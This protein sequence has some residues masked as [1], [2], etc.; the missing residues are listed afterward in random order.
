MTAESPYRPYPPPLQVARVVLRWSRLLMV[1]LRSRGRFKFTHGRGINLAKR[2]DIRAPH[3]VELGD[4][5]FFGKNFTCETD[6]R[7]GSEVMISSNVSM[8]G[9]D[10]PHDHPSLSVYFAPRRDTSVVEVGSDVLI[11]FGAVIIGS[12]KIGDG[13]IVGAGSVVTRNLPPHTICAGAPARPIRPRERLPE[14]Q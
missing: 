12:V 4:H 8:V 11:G 5:V 3:F 13:C 6:L 1:R 2:V 9:N 7:V 14:A 10:H